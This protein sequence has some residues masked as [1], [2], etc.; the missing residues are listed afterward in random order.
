M[1]SAIG[2]KDRGFKDHGTES[3]SD[4]DSDDREL[5]NDPELEKIQRNRLA[6]LKMEFE[7]K[8]ALKATGHGKYDSMN[9]AEVIQMFSEGVEYAVV[10][11]Y[12]KDFE[13]CKI[14][15]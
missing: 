5:L 12:H 9:E 6:R 4:L 2:S 8:K 3:D 1:E 10:H 15:D 7:A 14:I 13:R 11:F